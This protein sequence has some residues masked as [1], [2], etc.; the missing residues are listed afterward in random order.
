MAAS[1]EAAWE[2]EERAEVRGGARVAAATEVVLEVGTVGVVLAAGSVVAARA[3][4]G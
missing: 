3:G 2:A 4:E 1:R